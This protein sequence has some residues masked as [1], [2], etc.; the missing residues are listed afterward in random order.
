MMERPWHNYAGESADALFALASTHR[1]DS[2]VVAFET[3]LGQKVASLGDAALTQPERD[4]LAIEGLEREVNNGGYKQFFL[5][6]SNEYAGLVVDALRRIG[7]E[8]IAA[9][10]ARAIAALPEGVSLTPQSLSAEVERD[11]PERDERLGQCDAAYYD[12]R[13]DIA[14]ALLQY[15]LSRRDEIHLPV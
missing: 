1:A 5:N 12:A 3:A 15:L 6:S 10:T 4:V 14:T 13:E 11:D 2:L 8:T 7:C 9:I